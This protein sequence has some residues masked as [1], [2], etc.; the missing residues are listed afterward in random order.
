MTNH[1]E[2][3]FSVSKF[4]WFEVWKGRKSVVSLQVGKDPE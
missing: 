2:P 1:M 4:E 3:A